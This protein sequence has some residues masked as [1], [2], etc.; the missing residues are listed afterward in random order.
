MNGPG[1]YKYVRLMTGEYRFIDT[2]TL[3]GETHK[4]LVGADEQAETAAFIAVFDTHFRLEGYSTTLGLS[5]D[6]K[7]QEYFEKRLGLPEKGEWE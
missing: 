7:D 6:E 1:Y 4:S 3:S 2:A 5:W